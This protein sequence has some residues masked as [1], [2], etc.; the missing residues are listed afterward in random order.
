[1]DTRSSTGTVETQVSRV[2]RI[3]QKQSKKQFYEKFEATLRVE[4]TVSVLTQGWPDSKRGAPDISQ[5]GTSQSSRKIG[6]K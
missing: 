6:K 3:Q 4:R 2:T 5:P 1:M